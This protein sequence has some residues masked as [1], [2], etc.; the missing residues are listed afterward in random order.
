MVTRKI[1]MNTAV[2]EGAKENLN[3]FEYIEFLDKENIIPRNAKPWLNKLREIGN[4]ANHEIKHVK[5]EQ[6]QDAIKFVEILLKN[7]FEMNIE[8]TN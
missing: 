6:A 1:I 3:F 4:E 5:V 8:E 7:V 2:S